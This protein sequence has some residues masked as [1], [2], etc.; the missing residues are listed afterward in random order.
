MNDGWLFAKLPSGSTFSDA[1]NAFYEP[2]DLP[3]DWLIWQEKD[4]YES[5]DAWYRRILELPENHDPIV[6]IRFD[7]VYMDCDVLLNGEVVFTHP[8]GYTAFDVPLT[9]KLK[10][11]RNILTVHIRHHSPNSRWYSGSGIYRDV[12]LVTLPEDHVIPDSLYLKETEDNGKWMLDVSAMTAGKD[13]TAFS[14]TL[15]D[16]KGNTTA[17]A[18]GIS[19]AGKISVRL[20]IPDAR[21]WSPEDPFL[22]RLTIR[23]GE[24]IEIRRTGLRSVSVDPDKGMSLNGKP[25]K[26]KGVCLHHDLGALGSVFHKK[27]ARRQ[28][29]LMKDM[30]ANAVRTSHNP[31]AEKFLDLCDEM[32]MLVVDEAFDMWERPKTA[33]DYA[34]FFPQWYQEDV[35]SWIRRDRCHA[36]VI[37][38]SIGNEIYDMHAGFRG[39]EITKTLADLVRRHDPLRHAFITFGSNYMP[40]EGAQ[41]CAEHVDIV[42]YN[43]GERLYELHHSLHPSWVIYGSETA[44]ILSSRGI[45]HFPAGQSIMSDADMQCSALGNSNTSWGAESLK[46][47]ITDDLRNPF[48]LGQFLW[49]GIDYIGEPTPYHTRSCYFGQADTACFPKD[50]FY[51]IKS[52]WNEQNMIHIGVSWDWNTGQMIDVPVATNCFEA[53]LFL[54]GRTLGRKRNNVE[55]SERFPLLWKLPFHPGELTA[56]GYDEKGKLICTDHRYTPGD[57]DHFILSCEEDTLLSDGLD[58]VFVTVS[59]MDRED[60]PVENARERVK[61]HVS[62]G[63]RLIG[64]DNG[65][66]ADTD[67]YKSD[68]RRLF[69]GKLLLMIASDGKQQDVNVRIEGNDGISASMTIPVRKAPLLPGVSCHM[70]AF[71]QPFNDSSSIRRIDIQSCGITVLTKD[72]PECTFLYSAVSGNDPEPDIQWQATNDA[73]I[74]SPYVHVTHDNRTVTVRAYGDGMYY[75]R[76]LYRE[77]ERCILISQLEFSAT[78]LGVPALDPYGYISAG[79]YDLH[80]GKIGCG[81]EKGI[82]FA[83]G[84]ESMIGFRQIDFGR[85]GSDTLTADVFAL[86]DNAYDIELFTIYRDGTEKLIDVLHY[87]KKSIWNVYQPETWI[88]P[89]RLTGVRTLCFRMKEKIHLKGFFFEKQQSAWMYHEAGSA[90]MMYGD[91]FRREGNAVNGIGNN[92]TLTWTGMDFGCGG[93]AMLEIDGRTVLPVNTIIIRIKNFQGEEITGIADFTGCDG[94]AQHFSIRIPE[95]KCSV[96]F[97]FLPG[98]SFDFRGFRFFRGENWTDMP[99]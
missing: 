62:G 75:L 71:E 72:H 1:E 67:S 97:V 90:D 2:V 54:D 41:K 15:V 94:P 42:G 33:Y 98:C 86:D 23:Y 59:A 24:Q 51:L 6:M 89:E 49:S 63:G 96:S 99:E 50:S 85:T 32:G 11:G 82:A 83:Q 10:A 66:P 39:V 61:I 60:H 57:T 5:A 53:E 8:Y 31:P 47:I 46:K 37:M 36:C 40:W 26:L 16:P 27:A 38:W 14:C 25:V 81:N 64:T 30:G 45:Y 78:G 28:L 58:M 22:Y 9:G 29:K 65:N 7:G 13:G 69:S 56:K 18:D 70:K 84:E 52:L 93:A 3:H 91:S 19:E 48:S 34:R 95:G 20:T 43:Y 55:G 92:V 44:S 35:A 87:Q 79:L 68:C 73:G 4:L 76:A 77:R 21:P 88:L 17:Q 80:E 12:F 74:E